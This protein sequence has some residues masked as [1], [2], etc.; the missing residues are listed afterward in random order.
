VPVLRPIFD[1]DSHYY[2]SEDAF[3]RH[4]DQAS[5]RTTSVGS[6]ATTPSSSSGLSCRR[7]VIT[8]ARSGRLIETTWARAGLALHLG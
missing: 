4:Q 6:L 5:P 1:F 2:E 8:L 7:A 3:T